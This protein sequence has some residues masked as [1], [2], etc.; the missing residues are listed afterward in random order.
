MTWAVNYVLIN[1]AKTSQHYIKLK[2]S[3]LNLNHE[4]IHMVLNYKLTSEFLNHKLN[5]TALCVNIYYLLTNK[6]KT[7]QHC[8]NQTLNWIISSM[9]A[10][11]ETEAL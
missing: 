3:K 8:I 10:A 7:S 4:Y 11:T 5:F 2:F 6:A 9:K 1:K